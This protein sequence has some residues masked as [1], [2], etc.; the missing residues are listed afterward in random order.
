MSTELTNTSKLREFMEELKKLD[1]EIIKPSINKC[2]SDFKAIKGK[3][4]YG[5]GAIKN[6]GYEAISN[7]VNERENNGKFKSLIDFINRV[8]AKDVNKLQL[9]GLVKSGVFD[10]F[11]QDRSKILN[12]IPKI[13]QKIKNVNDEKENHQSNLFSEQE[14]EKKSFDFD[15]APH[16]SLKEL[17]SEEFKSIGFYL[18]NHPLNEFDDIFNQLNIVSYNQFYENDLNESLVAG[19]I[20]SIQE[21]KSSK[22]T[23]YAIVKFSDKKS[24]FELF[25]FAD[26]LVANREKLKESESFVLTLQKDRVIGEGKKRINVKKIL[27]LDE[28]INK[29]YSKVTIELK[30]NYNLNEIKSLLSTKG[31]TKI[32]IVIKEKNQQAY[33]T[34]QE[35]RKFDLNQLKALK[36]KKYVEKITV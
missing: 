14:N 23:P 1:I 22:G 9:E 18:T 19:T 7:I 13:I 10:E 35:N 32:N 29:P 21:K 34:L 27:N 20:M 30:N 11:D 26:I 36:A 33:F 4:Y 24:E 28:V 15:P 31:E 6:V 12:S 16:W 25:L 3:L 2:F 8:N 5:L 17:L